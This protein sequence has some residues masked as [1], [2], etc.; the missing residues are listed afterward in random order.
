[1]MISLLLKLSKTL[2]NGRMLSVYLLPNLDTIQRLANVCWLWN[3]NIWHMHKK[4]SEQQ[5]LK[6][7]QKDN[8]ILELQS[9][10]QSFETNTSL[11]RSTTSARNSQRLAKLSL[12]QLTHALSPNFDTS[13][14]SSCVQSLTSLHIS[15]KLIKSSLTTLSLYHWWCSRNEVERKLLSLS[16][17]S[18]GL[19][20]PIFEEQCAIELSNSQSIISHL[21]EAIGSHSRDFTLD[22]H[23]V[24]KKSKINSKA[25]TWWH[26]RFTS[27]SWHSSKRKPEVT[28][29]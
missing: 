27:A 8:A 26:Q 17:K 15:E 10:Q 1:M 18:R 5:K 2:W 19:G 4:P 20:I 23:I 29:T 14:R 11:K 7:Q 22:P 6:S 21:C 24:K 16:S 13:L 3:Q 9:A 25:K 12:G 28:F